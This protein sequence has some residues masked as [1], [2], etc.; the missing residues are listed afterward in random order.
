MSDQLQS[1]IDIS[2][3][4]AVR[5]VELQ[6]EK[7]KIVRELCSIQIQEAA[8]NLEKAEEV[9]QAI[10]SLRLLVEP[11]PNFPPPSYQEATANNNSMDSGENGNFEE[12]TTRFP[13]PTA[14]TT[15]FA[16]PTASAT[17]NPHFHHFPAHFIGTA[18]LGGMSLREMSEAMK[19][20]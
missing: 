19:K 18:A 14:I 5:N 16:E 15:W 13:D 17:S 8:E 20:P 2:V 1:A 9:L 10:K 12:S 11:E 7:C 6:R 4:T 3:N